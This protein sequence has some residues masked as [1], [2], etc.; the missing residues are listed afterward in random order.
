METQSEC[1]CT[2][3][4]VIKKGFNGEKAVIIFIVCL[5][6]STVLMYLILN[7][8]QSSMPV[9]YGE[10][11]PEYG[12]INTGLLS[13]FSLI[14]MLSLFAGTIGMNQIIKV[15]PTCNKVEFMTIN[16]PVVNHSHDQMMQG[17]GEK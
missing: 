6:I 5:V 1:K 12:F 14:T 13:I 17:F 11:R 9:G 2:N 7:S 10:V 8:E 16:N 3:V 4:Q 15:C